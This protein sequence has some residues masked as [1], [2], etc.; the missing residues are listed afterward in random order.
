MDDLEHVTFFGPD[1]A[2]LR[3][4]HNLTI[5]L[6]CHRTIAEPEVRHD[7]SQRQPSGNFADFA[8]NREPHSSYGGA[9]HEGC[10]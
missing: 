3:A 1:A 4:R 7:T 6:D 2:V 5:A 10:Q 8:V 9:T